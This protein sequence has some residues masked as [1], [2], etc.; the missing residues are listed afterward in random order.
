MFLEWGQLAYF[1]E[2]LHALIDTSKSV[3]IIGMYNKY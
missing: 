1:S 3:K 2:S